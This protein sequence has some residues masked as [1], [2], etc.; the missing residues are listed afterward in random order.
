MEQILEKANS[1]PMYLLAVIIVCGVL[2]QAVLYL[3]KAWKHGKEI[4][5][6][7]QVMKQAV[8]SSV[9]FTI[10]P[11]I[12]IL[13]GVLALAPSLGIPIP[14]IRLSVL[15][16]LQY[17]SST[18]N[19]LAKGLGI[20]ELPSNMMTAGDY[21]SIVLGM[22][23]T[24]LSGL[25]FTLFFFRKYQ[26][27]ILNKAKGDPKASDILLSSMFIGMIAAYLGDAVS[28][29][30]SVQVSGETRTP[31]IL[32]LIAFGTA[33]AA[34]SFFQ[35]L[36]KKKQIK[37]LESYALSFSMLIGMAC[38]VLGQFLFPGMSTFL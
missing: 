19:N 12:G 35:M 21:A 9:S 6:D 38:A 15:G 25:I 2:I 18:A 23:V 7:E 20:G 11:S 4:G 27:R 5:M 28:Y 8:Q 13:I 31:N 30:R 36:I 16:A 32:P 17:E 34:M 1:F 33:M 10:V 3:K 26:N 14:W 29:L 37:W 22:S 24:I